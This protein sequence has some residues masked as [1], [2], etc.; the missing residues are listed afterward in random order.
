MLFWIKTW[1]DKISKQAGTIAQNT[2]LQLS[3]RNKNIPSNFE[4][5]YQKV[6]ICERKKALLVGHWAR[7]YGIG[8]AFDCWCFMRFSIWFLKSENLYFGILTI[9]FFSNCSLSYVLETLPL[10]PLQ[11]SQTN[12]F[13][14]SIGFNKKYLVNNETYCIKSK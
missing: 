13:C 4:S 10:Q 12:Q 9:V 8:F 14:A 6:V 7:D 11:S 5:L 1:R 3:I 2:L